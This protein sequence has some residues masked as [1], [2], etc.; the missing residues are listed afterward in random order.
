VTRAS[1]GDALVCIVIP[2][3]AEIQL[4][5][6]GVQSWTP[7]CAGVT[8]EKVIGDDVKRCEA[9]HSTVCFT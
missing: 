8:S 2:T 1:A 9:S 6:F 4:R 5:F 7:A 3:K